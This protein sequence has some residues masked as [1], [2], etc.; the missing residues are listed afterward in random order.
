M[1]TG[2][3]I[4]FSVSSKYN[5][6]Y[7]VSIDGTI[8]YSDQFIPDT[9]I[10][11][12]SDGY[13]F[14]NHAVIIWAKSID[15]IETF[16]E[17]EFTV[18]SNSVTLIQIY[19]LTGCEF[20]SSGNYLNFSIFSDYPDY[21]ELWIDGIMV[22]TDTF[23]SGEYI[24]YSLDNYTDVLGNHT[25]YIWAIGLDMHIGTTQAVFSVYS[26]SVTRIEVNDLENIEFMSVDNNL[27]FTIYSYYPDYYELWIDDVLVDSNNFSNGIPITFS[28]DAYASLMGNHSVFI[29]A[30]GIDGKIATSNAEGFLVYSSSNTIIS[31]LHLSDYEFLTMG[32]YFTF[33]V[34][35]DFP[36][37]FNFSIDGILLNSSSFL[38]GQLF[39]FS[40]DGCGVG[41]HNITIWAI[42]SDGK[43]AELDVYFEVYS[44][45]EL[46][47]EILELKDYLYNSTGNEFIFK[48][49][50]KY[51]YY[52]ELYI[53]GIL[54]DSN[55]CSSSQTI[56]YSIDGLEIGSHTININ[57]SVIDGEKAYIN[58]RFT[59]NALQEEDTIPDIPKRTSRNPKY[60]L[61]LI[62]SSVLTIVP[63]MIIVITSLYKKKSTLLSLIHLKNN[64]H[65]HRYF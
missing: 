5:G 3:L 29:W 48:I 24:L 14:G 17:T 10:L 38:N 62:L 52:Y 28:L 56:S 65:I 49:S 42:G 64:H 36:D 7:A 47:I 31:I 41:I 21:F 32:N 51:A 15:G 44:L 33:Q 59:V 11:C 53:D 34:Y 43:I 63:G 9:I 20:L 35:S 45:S 46:E 61:A 39:N 30:I 37:Y 19:N 57:V 60:V 12:S 58:S 54:V 50:C 1:T 40:I 25:V 2:N 6:N 55:S 22:Y 26:T 8:I 16:Y 18:F 27:I 13:S 4:N 23:N